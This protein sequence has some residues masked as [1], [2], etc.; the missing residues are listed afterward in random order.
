[1]RMEPSRMPCGPKRAPGRAVTAFQMFSTPPSMTIEVLRKKQ[2]KVGS[3]SA[4]E[5]KRALTGTNR[6]E[7][8]SKNC[9][10]IFLDILVC[11]G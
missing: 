5:S 9:N 6:V 10:V 3:G 7:G 2:N 4:K 11:L 1:M 8:S